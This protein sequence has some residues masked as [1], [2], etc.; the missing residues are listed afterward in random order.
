MEV[1]IFNPSENREKLEVIGTHNGVF[2]SDE[3]VAIA[4]YCLAYPEKNIRICRTR[5]EEVLKKCDLLIDIG[6]GK[7]DHHQK[8]GNGARE[9]GIKYAS[10]GLVWR[11]YGKKVLQ[12]FLDYRLFIDVLH[13]KIDKDISIID[14]EDNGEMVEKHTF[15]Y[16]TRFLPYW[17]ED[18]NRYDEA[19]I[20]VLNITIQMLKAEI[21]S[22]VC[23]YM[24]N[25]EIERFYENG[26]AC[27][28]MIPSQNI[29]WLKPVVEHNKKATVKTLFVV[30]PYPDG[31]YAAQCVPPSLEE[32]FKQIIPFPKEWAGLTGK[33]LQM[34]SGVR[35][36][37][38]CHNGCFF[39]R[40]ET[41]KAI[42]KMCNIA[43]KSYEKQ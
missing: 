1:K 16:V 14:Q 13:D 6:G 8:G 2:H 27:V 9:N 21:K 24:A 39:A 5:D 29:P 25:F 30:F 35:E 31:G 15:S 37:T 18:Q 19:F 20:R 28:I 41:K 10:C 42:A 33:E 17:Y 22:Y 36:A 23:E 34:A 43:M 7:F 26:E 11:E 3:V 12:Y 4:I 38:F 32:K 40:A